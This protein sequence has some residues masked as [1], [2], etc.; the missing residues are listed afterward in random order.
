MKRKFCGNCG[1]EAWQNPLP[2]KPN[3]DQEFRCVNCGRPARSG[4]NAKNY[5]LKIGG[6]IKAFGPGQEIR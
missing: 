2:K 5:C 3:R 1:E 6:K 4:G